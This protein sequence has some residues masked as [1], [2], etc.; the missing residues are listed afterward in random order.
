[1]KLIAVE[2]NIGSGKSTVLPQLAQEI[3][4]EFIQEPVDDPK[5][6]E[7]LEGFTKNPSSTSKRLEFQQ[8]ITSRRADL[9]KDIPDGNY[10]IERSLYSDL[11]FSQVN[12]LG[13]ERP[14]GA[15]LSYYYDIKD[16]LK[17]YPQVDAVVYLKTSPLICHK[18]MQE[19]GRE[20][21]KGTPLI[22]LADVSRFHDACLPQICREYGADFMR[23]EWDCFGAEWGGIK[24]VAEKL[25]RRGYA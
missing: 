5:F 20:E 17:D 14:D 11:V 1:M 16:R 18:R 10:I 12:M 13:M 4:F 15:Y 23:F 19:R 6:L 7:L 25:R 8:Y 24:G 21:E 22:Y 9:L 3:G 2:G